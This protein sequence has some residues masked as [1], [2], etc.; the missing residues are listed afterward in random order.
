MAMPRRTIE[1]S[2]STESLVRELAREGES[3][4]AAATRLIEA[5][6]AAG[7]PV[8][9]YVGIGSGPPEELGRNHEKYLRPPHLE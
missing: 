6:A 4:S 3:L 9:S 1:I 2:E 8:P 5:G 7:K